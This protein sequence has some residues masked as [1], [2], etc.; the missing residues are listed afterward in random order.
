MRRPLVAIPGRFSASASALRYGALVN[1]QALLRMVFAA[2]GEPVT[3]L[4]HAP[5]G[6][7]DPAEVA[8]RLAFADAVLLPGGADVDPA[9]Y[10][11]QVASTEVYDVD[12]EQ[13][14]FDLAVARHALDRGL[15]LLAICRG[16]HVVN[17]AEG[18]SLVQ[19]MDAPH[20]HV[21]HE[22]DVVPGSRLAGAVL[23]QLSVSCYHHQEVDRLGASLAVTARAADGT[24]EA[25][26]RPGS[27]GW[28][29]G[30]QWHPEDTYLQDE[31]QACI[32]KAFLAAR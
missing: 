3:L 22:V 31:R 21:V 30:L 15:P 16:L 7:A 29:L 17:V 9:R 27:A 10:G 24:V 26:E 14:G 28:F 11:Q 13:D 25:V 4:P 20:R 2:G 6:V 1:A 8:D 12:A 18:G 32:V 23:E 5:G 19:H